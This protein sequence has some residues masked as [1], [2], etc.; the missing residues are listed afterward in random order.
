MS[1]RP[2]VSFAEVKQKVSIPDVLDV[3]GLT[4]K[5]SR[6]GDTLTGVCPQG[7]CAMMGNMA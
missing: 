2:Y 4:E 3:F 7:D 1:T 6:K 5:F